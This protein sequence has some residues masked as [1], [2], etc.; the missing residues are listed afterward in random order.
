MMYISH[1]CYL[2]NS[3]IRESADLV[4]VYLKR[5]NVLKDRDAKLPV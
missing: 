2:S 4:V 3:G 5:A 1:P